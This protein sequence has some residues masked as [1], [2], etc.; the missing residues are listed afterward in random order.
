[1]QGNIEHIGKNTFLTQITQIIT[2]ITVAIRQ[3]FVK[4]NIKTF[5]EQLDD[6]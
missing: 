5:E 6:Y 3:P 4:M 1:M 2:E